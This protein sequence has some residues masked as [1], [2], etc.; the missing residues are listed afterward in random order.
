MHPVGGI[1]ISRILKWKREQ[2]DK[3]SFQ[4]NSYAKYS[5]SSII[6]VD[7][8]KTACVFLHTKISMM[9]KVSVSN[10]L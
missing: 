5:F 10:H 7:K 2:S 1:Y 3:Y 6:G 8:K 9:K 4:Q